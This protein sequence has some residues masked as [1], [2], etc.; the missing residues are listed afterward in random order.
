MSWQKLPNGILIKKS[1]I[2]TYHEDITELGYNTHELYP[3]DNYEIES[4]V[5]GY[6]KLLTNELVA[7]HSESDLLTNEEDMAL[8]KSSNNKIMDF[9]EEDI[10]EKA[11]NNH[12][13][14]QAYIESIYNTKAQ[15]ETI[16]T[17]KYLFKF[18]KGYLA[19]FNSTTGFSADARDFLNI[20]KYMQEAENWYRGNKRR[21]ID[22]INLQ[23][24]CFTEIN[25]DILLSQ[26]AIKP[27][28]YPNKCCNYIALAAHYKSC[29]VDFDAIINST[30]GNYEL[31]EKTPHLTKFKAY[32]VIYT[33]TNKANIE[34]ENTSD[35]FGY[36][37]V[38]INPSIPNLVKI[39]KTL[40]D[41]YERAKELS[42]AT[43]V[44][45]PF[46]VV[47]YKA[48]SNCHLAEAAIHKY[49][50][51]KG[52]RINSNREFFQ[53]TPTE[54]INFLNSYYTERNTEA[55]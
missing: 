2:K 35:T 39:G 46:I 42:S 34:F 36:V 12:G 27:F 20:N 4:R 29:E 26:D 25:F 23:A 55:D 24:A 31:I 15:N 48:F 3:I 7:I 13:I 40:R 8:Y 30:H 41:P 52:M 54:A 47:Y 33:G 50:E 1:P 11:I 5:V 49:L 14:S 16:S 10:L 51:E 28:M 6:F 19:A 9:E 38:M 17:N 22:E 43:G 44:P 45:T 21:I 37:Y 53:T 18:H 32:G